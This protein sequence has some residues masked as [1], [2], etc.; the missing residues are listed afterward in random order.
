MGAS[1]LPWALA[2][3]GFALALVGALGGWC[4]SSA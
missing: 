1:I 3:I 2:A 4:F